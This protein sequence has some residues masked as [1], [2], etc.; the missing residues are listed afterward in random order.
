MESSFNGYPFKK[1]KIRIIAHKN[2][3]PGWE[4]GD[5][6]IDKK[7]ALQIRV[8]EYENADA[9]IY[10]VIHELMEAWRTAK[11]G[12][13]MEA[14]DTFDLAHQDHPD[15]GLLPDAPYHDEHIKSM[16]IEYL[17]SKQDGYSF[18]EIYECKPIGM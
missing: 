18:S 4:Y 15:P 12:V 1:I 17:M 8:A 7:G 13:T 3:R 9:A 14:I 2:M 6:W 10:L 16:E 11:R 5:Y